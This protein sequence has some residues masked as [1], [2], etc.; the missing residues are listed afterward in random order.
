[1]AAVGDGDRW[2]L[3]R[4]MRGMRGRIGGVWR[5]GL[6]CGVDVCAYVCMYVPGVGKGSVDGGRMD[7]HVDIAGRVIS[8]GKVVKI[9]TT[10]CRICESRVAPTMCCLV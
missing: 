8:D 4:G 9:S 2:V 5:V 6:M 10:K 3:R 1:M 7:M